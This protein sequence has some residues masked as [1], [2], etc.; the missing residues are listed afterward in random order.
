MKFQYGALL[1]FIAVPIADGFQP[2]SPIVRGTPISTA[3]EVHLS[4][5]TTSAP[6]KAS[7]GKWKPNKSTPASTPAPAA[8]GFV[9][10]GFVADAAAAPKAGYKYKPNFT[11]SGA[12]FLKIKSGANATATD[13]SYSAPEPVAAA[14]VAAAAAPASGV[15]SGT[16]GYMANLS[17]GSGSMKSSGYKY[18]PNT[19]PTGSAFLKTASGAN[20]TTTSAAAPAATGAAPAAWAPAGGAK[21]SYKYKPNFAPSGSAF[22]KIKSGANATATDASY[23]APEPAAPVASA[24]AS[25][26]GGYMDSMSP[27]SS[28]MKS[29]GYKYKPNTTPTGSAFLKIK[30]GANATA[31]E[32]SYSAPAAPAA[33]VVSNAA[34]AGVASGTGGYMA[35]LSPQTGGYKPAQYKYNPKK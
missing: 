24:P 2:L 30:S 3:R 27:K 11:P 7:Y 20:A 25:G 18:K 34:P 9:A 26:T 32:S 22:L 29:S 10:N 13:S 8:N 15:A 17:P 23:S 5:L 16:G 4:D 28:G 14:P 35:N 33:P 31:T 1:A 21:T 12:A 19:K 6:P